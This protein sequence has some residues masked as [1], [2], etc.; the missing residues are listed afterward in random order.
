MIIKNQRFCASDLG[1]VDTS[2]PRVTYLY[3]G[4][5]REVLL[6]NE[7]CLCFLMDTTIYSVQCPR[8]ETGNFIAV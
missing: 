3:Q 8:L 6:A 2:L 4:D 7:R 5:V 1:V